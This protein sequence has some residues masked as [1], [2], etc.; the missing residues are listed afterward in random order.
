MT[1]E[2]LIAR[3]IEDVETLS[4]KS[5]FILRHERLVFEAAAKILRLSLALSFGLGPPRLFFP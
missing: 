5:S 1:P 3:L 2:E 4:A